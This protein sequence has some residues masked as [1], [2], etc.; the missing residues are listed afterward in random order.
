MPPADI[1]VREKCR[2]QQQQ[3][4]KQKRKKFNIRY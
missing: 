3:G 1:N 4:S 2:N